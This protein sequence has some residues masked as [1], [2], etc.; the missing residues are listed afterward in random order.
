MD[1]EENSE[2]SN[3]A[4]FQFHVLQKYRTLLRNISY[5]SSNNVFISDRTF[6]SV[7]SFSENLY[8]QKKLNHFSCCVINDCFNDIDN[9]YPQW[10][11]KGILYLSVL[12]SVSVEWMKKRGRLEEETFT[13]M[14]DYLLHL[15]E[16]YLKHMIVLSEQGITVKYCNQIDL[17][18]RLKIAN[19]FVC[20]LQQGSKCD[21]M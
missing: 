11:P 7:K 5:Q 3:N 19:E 9:L 12:P 1:T 10:R 21:H 4:V 6:Y 2:K 18:S 15:E 20:D 13:D 17:E 14:C 16:I 8:H